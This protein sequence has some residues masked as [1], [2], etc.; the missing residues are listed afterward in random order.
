[1][2][3]NF[4]SQISSNPHLVFC[5]IHPAYPSRVYVFQIAKGGQPTMTEGTTLKEN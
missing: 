1:V 2:D 5:F 3:T 4:M